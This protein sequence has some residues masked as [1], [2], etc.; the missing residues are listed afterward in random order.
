MIDK[1]HVPDKLEG[2][3]LQTR[4]A[5]FELISHDSNRVVSVEAYDDV[6]FENDDTLVAEQL[7][8][9][10]SDNNPLADRSV[11]LWKTIY[12]WSTYVS[13]GTLGKKKLE[14]RIVV[15]AS[16]EIR[17]GSIVSNFANAKDIEQAKE[18]LQYAKNE[19]VGTDDSP[20][21]PSKGIKEYI[22]YCFAEE[23]ETYVLTV[24]KLLSIELHNR[25]YDNKLKER[26][27]A[28]P[29]P[30]EYI[31]ELFTYMLG[32]VEEQIH[33][34]TQKNQPAFLSTTDYINELRAQIQ[35]YDVNKILVAVSTIPDTTKTHEE[36]AQRSSYIRQLEFID[37]G[38]T[39]MFEAASDFLRSQVEKTEWGKRG[40]V[41]QDSIAD[42]NDTLC[43][44]WQSKRRIAAIQFKG[45]GVVAGQYT[46]SEC[47]S[48]V[49][50]QRLQGCDVP[51]FFGSGC[52]HE[53]A[54]KPTTT[55]KIGWHPNYIQLLNE[56]GSDGNRH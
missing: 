8:S 29:I 6:A 31:N 37:M 46:Y 23:N 24:I 40:L 10:L 39:E 53:L 52:L 14:L 41:T 27:F 20:K 49:I 19:L 26:F 35:R 18:A 56:E 12:N 43:R 9:V 30:V 38:Y 55:P 22:D 36:V 15:A 44:I 47:K 50:N 42:Y 48:Q 32:W 17:P 13:R 21:I 1:T 11:V 5:L 33:L 28:Q 3:L 34:Q 7:K 51:P 2:Y 25:D 54:N 45:D 16:H 4:H